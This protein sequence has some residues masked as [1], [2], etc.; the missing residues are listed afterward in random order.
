M[1][2]QQKIKFDKLG[3]D[4]D[5][6]IEMKSGF[7]A[8]YNVRILSTDSE[9]GAITTSNGNTLVLFTLPSG[10]NTSIGYCEDVLTKK[11]Y[12]FIYNSL[13][14]HSIIQH[15]QVTNTIA[16]VIRNKPSFDSTATPLNFQ[17]TNLITSCFVVQITNDIYELYWTDNYHTADFTIYNEPKCID[18]KK[19]LLYMSSGG[20]DKNGYFLDSA[21]PTFNP[22]W[23]DRIVA[24]PSAPTYLWIGL[25]SQLPQ[26]NAQV[27]PD[28][29]TNSTTYTPIGFPTTTVNLPPPV[30]GQF[31]P[32]T[33]VW[34]CPATGYYNLVSG[35]RVKYYTTG[36][37]FTASVGLNINGTIVLTKT[38][39]TFSSG[40]GTKYFDIDIQE[41]NLFFTA[42]DTAEI[43]IKIDSTTTVGAYITVTDLNLTGIN[44][45]W[46]IYF[47]GI[48]A[49]INNNNLFKRLFKFQ[50]Q[51]GYKNKKKSVLSQKTDY[52]LPATQLN[53]IQSTGEDYVIQDNEIVI[54]VETGDETVENIY[55]YAHEINVQGTDTIS[56][57][58]L[59][60]TLNKKDL[61]IGDNTTYDYTFLNDG[62]YTPLDL[63]TATQLF[64]NIFYWE[65]S[66]EF[67]KD[68]IADA[69]GADN[70]DAVSVDMRFPI[71]FDQTVETNINSFFPA[72]SYY[73]S[74]AIYEEGIEYILNG[75]RL[76]NA[77]TATGESNTLN[78]KG[79]YGT[80]VYVPFLTEAEY[81]AP[82]GYPN[83]KME[84]VPTVKG[85]IYH[86]PPIDAVGYN[87]VRSK[88]QNIESYLQFTSEAIQYSD[89][90]R[91]TIPASQAY[92]VSIYI[93]NI[94]GRYKVENP[95]SNLVY[96]W[97]KGDRIRFIANDVTNPPSQSSNQIDQFFQYNDT[98]ILSFDNGTQTVMILM[99]PAVPLDLDA[100]GG[101]CLFEIYTPA[102]TIANDNEFLYEVGEGGTI[103]K[104]ANGN[105]IHIPK[106]NGLTII[107][108][109][110]STFLTIV[111]NSG[112]T[113][114]DLTCVSGKEIPNGRNVKLSTSTW[115]F[116]GTV[117]ASGSGTMSISLESGS[118]LGVITNVQGD[119]V[120][121]SEQTFTSGDCFRRYC[122]MP[123]SD[124]YGTTVYRLYQYIET[125]WASNCWSS[126]AQTEAWDYGRPNLIN[127]NQKRLIRS[128]DASWS[129]QLIPNTNINGLSTVY[130][131]SIQNYN[132]AFGGIMRMLF[133]NDRLEFY[134][135]LKVL[136]VLVNQQL[137]ESLSGQPITSST[138]VILSPQGQYNTY[139]LAN[140]GITHPESLATFD[141]RSYFLDV[142]N[143]ALVRRSNDGLINLP[144]GNKMRIAFA[145]LCTA[146]L[147]AGHYVNCVGTYDIRYGTYILM[148]APFAAYP[149]GFTIEW[150][151]KY[152]QFGSNWGYNGD[153]IG[154]S[155]N[156]IISF[157]NGG[158]WTHDTNQIQNNFYGQQQ[159]SLITFNI[160]LESSKVKVLEAMSQETEKGQ[161]WVCTE[162][163]TPNGQLTNMQF[164]SNWIMKEGNYY[165]YVKRDANTVN[166]VGNPLIVGNV[167]R[168]RAFLA[169]LRYDKTTFSKLYA[170]NC[171][172][173][174]SN[175]SNS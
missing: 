31:N 102:K 83:L 67:F 46:N 169:T 134:Q 124:V 112:T 150:N 156:N 13:A 174:P 38:T 85:Q 63:Q 140:Y 37:N 48:T 89:I 79:V 96:D 159:Y 49:K 60:S 56:D 139:Y 170:V 117:V 30:G 154:Q 118:L 76:S 91:T 172:M 136:A 39:G 78:N 11:G 164:D 95:N 93:S 47:V 145:N 94:I 146:I 90:N 123:W 35:L 44:S 121:C 125:M 55:I 24:P 14:N 113:Y 163:S 8:L 3:Q 84:Y 45:Y 27:S 167:L 43:D 23:I 42:G 77:S 103:G 173:I 19:G 34:T 64:D 162:I 82:S 51:Y 1:S 75:G 81:T 6:A 10:N 58:S 4:S 126:L 40:V 12:A 69:N 130:D 59:I 22:H 133:I 119:I 26:V 97:T 66:S 52:I 127:N 92:Y 138:P 157:K 158:L 153:Y 161:N 53:P 128:A 100:T 50:S 101:N 166:V 152:N 147:N 28:F 16:Y 135:T 116:Y 7:T 151:E 2:V 21:N 74:G 143:A 29:V 131:T 149:N 132:T 142:N 33:G 104:D 36:V 120:A 32:S 98:E 107:N 73:K 9:D 99:T 111:Y 141:F 105:Y 171:Y 160:N 129:E 148:V 65:Q 5:S 62:N 20:T 110:F 18:I 15:D 72:K 168:D 88:M 17:L 70:C 61:G 106:N 108:Q 175:R 155:G 25:A 41:L 137:I 54:T 122:N 114:Y 115:S 71:T 57:I 165:S 144:M 87:I 109:L 86:K 80:S 68:R